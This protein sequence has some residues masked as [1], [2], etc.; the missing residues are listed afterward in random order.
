MLWT[1]VINKKLYVIM[2][3]ELKKQIRSILAFLGA[4]R[5]FNRIPK[6]LVVIAKNAVAELIDV[7][8]RYYIILSRRIF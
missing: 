8:F 2:E 3:S 1:A 6:A 7:C 5:A 4:V